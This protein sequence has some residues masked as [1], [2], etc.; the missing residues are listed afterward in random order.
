MG[1]V[2]YYITCTAPKP[3]PDATAAMRLLDARQYQQAIHALTPL[4]VTYPDSLRWLRF[5][6]FAFDEQMRY[7]AGI[8]DFTEVL[9]R[10]SHDVVSLN[11]RGY[12]LYQ[13]GRLQDAVTDYNHALTL[14]S[15]FLPARSN[16][17]L[18]LVA[19]ERYDS[20][21]QDIE[22]AI[23]SGSTTNST[24]YNLQGYCLLQ[25]N[26]P[27]AAIEAFSEAIKLDA[28]YSDALSNRAAAYRIRDS[29]ALT[30]QAH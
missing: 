23:N 29:A 25:L 11:N 27:A 2:G 17:A 10:N 24:L 6:G 1:M 30:H 16:R 8:A 21:L 15:A 18:V 22:Q 28:G 26:H 3:A 5:R 20:A 13:S 12:A 19:L 14:N 4:L 7:E 9:R